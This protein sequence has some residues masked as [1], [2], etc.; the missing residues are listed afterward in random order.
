VLP[1]CHASLAIVQADESAAH[2]PVYDDPE[3][4][5]EDSGNLKHG[6]AQQGLE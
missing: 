2:A 1:V 4:V 6:N 5:S 3:E